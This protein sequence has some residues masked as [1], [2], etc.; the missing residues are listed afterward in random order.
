M[1]CS[2]GAAVGSVAVSDASTAGGVAGADA[3]SVVSS[4][5]VG[6]SDVYAIAGRQGKAQATANAVTVNG[7]ASLAKSFAAAAYIGDDAS[8]TADALAKVREP[9]ALSTAPP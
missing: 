9:L 8:A 4:R 3:S 2:S 5:G 7:A 1:H 6:A